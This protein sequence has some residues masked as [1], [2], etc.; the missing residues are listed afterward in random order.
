[1]PIHAVEWVFLRSQHERWKRICC[2][3]ICTI[4]LLDQWLTVFKTASKTRNIHILSITDTTLSRESVCLIHIELG[5]DTAQWPHLPHLGIQEP[6]EV[7]FLGLDQ[8]QK[9]R[10]KQTT[11][12]KSKQQKFRRTCSSNPNDEGPFQMVLFPIHS[13]SVDLDFSYWALLNHVLLAP[14]QTWSFPDGFFFFF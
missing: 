4:I 6:K 14:L 5:T 12:K 3:R 2:F 8:Q 13:W 1:M 10:S 11:N 7:C 9:Q